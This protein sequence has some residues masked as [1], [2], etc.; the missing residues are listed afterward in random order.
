MPADTAAF[1]DRGKEL[2]GITATVTAAAAAGRVVAIHAIDGMPGVG[3][4]ALAVHVGPL[5]ADRQLFLDLH[6]HTAGPEPV[7]PEAALTSLLTADGDNAASSGQ[8]AP[9]L[10][11]SAGCLVRVT[12]RHDHL[13]DEPVYRRYR[14][15]DLIRD[16]ARAL[17]T[18]DHA[19]ERDQALGRL[20]D[21][22]QHTAA[23]ARLTLH[24]GPATTPAAPLAAARGLASGMRCP[25]TGM[26][27]AALLILGHA[28]I[29]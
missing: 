1:T 25:A 28:A 23:H 14:M 19:D 3:K 15:H 9:L 2:H 10:P 8:V 11:G 27:A 26:R 5:L 6:T 7:K 12:S 29:G 4:T 21:Y 22:Y 24:S 16:Y 18:T 17:A 13:L 20:L